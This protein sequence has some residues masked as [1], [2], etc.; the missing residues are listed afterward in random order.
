MTQT[1][2]P[3]AE[4]NKSVVRRFWNEFIGAGNVA[5]ADELLAPGYVNMIVEG[6][7]PPPAEPAAA[8]DGDDATR[9]AAAVAE[10]HVAVESVRFDVL[11]MAAEGDAVFARLN[12]VATLKDGTTS[13][14]RG[15]GYYQ[16]A[17]GK[18][19]MNDVLSVAPQPS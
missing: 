7:A 16:I 19:V 11:A 13:V 14:A 12:I 6:L 2:V 3:Q 18:I 15:L 17:D 5:L 4:T 9:L 8:P 10:F 1:S